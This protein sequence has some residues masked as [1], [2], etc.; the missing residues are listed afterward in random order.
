MARAEIRNPCAN[1]N[2]VSKSRSIVNIE[3]FSF[4]VLAG[5]MLQH[6]IIHFSLHYLSRGRLREVKTKEIFKLLALKVIA[7][8]YERWSLTRGSKNDMVIWLGSCWY[9]RIVKE[10]WSFTTNRSRVRLSHVSCFFAHVEPSDFRAYSWVWNRFFFIYLKLIMGYLRS[11]NTR[12][13][14]Q[15]I[16]FMHENQPYPPP[17]SKL[18]S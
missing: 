3:K 8:A 6:L 5:D 2:V 12:Y 14:K 9:Y 15:N 13:D 10:R 1:A 18:E 7:V 17:L 11:G 4:L 16:F